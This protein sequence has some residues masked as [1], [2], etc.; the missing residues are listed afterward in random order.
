[1]EEQLFKNLYL[2][3]NN[4]F[5]KD[6]MTNLPGQ[7]VVLLFPNSCRKGSIEIYPLAQVEPAMTMPI[8]LDGFFT[9]TIPVET[10][11]KGNYRL[12][13]RWEDERKE[14]YLMDELIVA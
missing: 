5:V 13:V 14:H 7:D 10:L 1:L 6:M 9:Q 12:F 11:S 2:S 3:N 4:I 8:Q